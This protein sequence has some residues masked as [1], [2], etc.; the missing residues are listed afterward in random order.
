MRKKIL[1]ALMA[2]CLFGQAGAIW[3]Q[4]EKRSIDDEGMAS[5]D[6][7]TRYQLPIVF[8]GSGPS[9][10][11]GNIKGPRNLSKFGGVRW[12]VNAGVEQRFGKYFGAKANL[13]Y[14]RTAGEKHTFTEFQ[15]FQSRLITGDLRFA[16]HFDHLLGKFEAVTPFVAVGVG[17][18]NFRTKSDLRDSDD[19]IYHLWDDGSFRDQPQTGQTNGNPVELQ[20]DFSYETIVNKSGNTVIFPIELGLRFKLHDYFDLGLGYTHTFML[21]RFLPNTGIKG[22]D[23]YGYLS[24]TVYWYLG[25]FKK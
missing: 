9:F 19:R 5:P 17:Y 22:T 15:N 1:V 4:K 24:G 10:Y 12:G 23:H 7:D 2:A 6:A 11:T 25:Q 18:I 20:R 13:F 3:A 21:N 8:V 16:F 14:G